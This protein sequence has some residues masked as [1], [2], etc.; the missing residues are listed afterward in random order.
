VCHSLTITPAGLPLGQ[1]L[2]SVGASCRAEVYNAQYVTSDA[3]LN[4]SCYGDLAG[5]KY[6]FNESSQDV[7]Y[8]LYDFTTRPFTSTSMKFST[9]SSRLVVSSA[10]PASQVRNLRSHLQLSRWSNPP[11]ALS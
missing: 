3:D 6:Y 11:P 10:L 9:Q 1:N 4:F 7:L 2:G 8:D 5:A